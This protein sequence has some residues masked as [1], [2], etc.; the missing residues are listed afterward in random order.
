MSNGGLST[1]AQY[2]PYL[3]QDGF[4][5]A[6]VTA[7]TVR[8]TGYVNVTSGSEAALMAAV[9]TV[10]PISISIDA[11]LDSFGYFTTGVYDD[12]NVRTRGGGGKGCV[13]AA[14][15]P[16]VLARDVQCSNQMAD[17]D[18]TIVLA[19][20]G[21]DPVSG[22]DYWIARNSWSTHWGDDGYILIARQGNICG[23]TLS[24]TY[25]T[26]Q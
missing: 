12:P 1:R 18:H 6:N 25:V 22:L 3:G 20:Y 24:P 21:T 23:V 7:P 9:A 10:G 4:C 19:G 26:I 11:S 2:S 5:R 13:G 17:Q 16:P 8:V 15:C 14:R